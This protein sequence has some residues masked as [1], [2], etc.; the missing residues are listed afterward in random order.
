M[1]YIPTSLRQEYNLLLFF[2]TTRT[3][4]T[5]GVF[6]TISAIPF[7]FSL[8]TCFTCVRTTIGTTTNFCCLSSDRENR[9][10]D[11]PN[12]RQ[13]RLCSGLKE[14]A[15]RLQVLLIFV[16]HNFIKFLWEMGS[17]SPVSIKRKAWN[18]YS[19]LILLNAVRPKTFA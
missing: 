11:C 14:L 1:S 3:S 2:R 12:Y 9:K 17:A 19:T 6:T 16:I 18:H 4:S 8:T 15:S 5:T 7:T 13:C 10:Y